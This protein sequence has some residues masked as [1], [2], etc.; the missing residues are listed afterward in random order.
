M[1]GRMMFE[2]RRAVLYQLLVMLGGLG[3]SQAADAAETVRYLL[4]TADRHLAGQQVVERGDDGVVKVRYIFKDNGRGPELVEHIRLSPDGTLA[5]FHVTGTAE[6]GGPIDERFVREG[7]RARWQSAAERGHTDQAEGAFYL[8]RDSSWEVVSASI[9]AAARAGGTLQLLPSGTLTQ[10]KVDEVEVVRAVASAG[11]EATPQRRRVQL[12]VQSGTDFTPA[13]YWATMDAVPHVFAVILPGWQLAIEEGWE[14]HLDALAARQKVASVQWL[15]ALAGRVARPLPGLTVVRN[16]RIF[17]SVAA[18]LRPP[19]DVYLLRGRITAVRP[20][21]S[22]AP[23]AQREIDAAGRVMLPG[24]FDMHGH[25][26]RSGGL[27]HLAAGVTT[28]RDMGSDNTLLQE[29]IDEAQAGDLLWPHIV[30]CGLLEGESP[31][32]SRL[33]TKIKT[34]EEAQAG[35][36]WYAA[37]GYRQVKIYNSFPRHL[38]AQTVAYAKRRGMRVSGHVPAFMRAAEVVEHGFDEIQHINQVVLNFLVT[39]R[40]DTRTLERFVLPA[41]RLAS[42]D[43]DSAPVREF[44]SL[45]KRKRI[46]IDPTLAVFD[47]LKQRDGEKSAPYAAVFDH[48]PPVVQRWM[49][50]GGMKMADDAAAARY[51]ASYAKAVQFVGRL[52]RAGVP[53]VAGTDALPGFTLHSELELYVQAGLTP[54]EALQVATLN[55]ARYS[56]TLASRGSIDIGKIADLVLVDGDPTRHIGDLRRVALVI[57]QGKMVFPSAIYRAMGVAPFVEPMQGFQADEQ[58]T[59]G[60][61]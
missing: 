50:S 51:A 3:L 5:E 59:P 39:P 57:T 42:L 19:A 21:G 46:V 15:K 49:L 26:W 18:R 29:I 33:G 32:S 12:I 53:L 10:L 28:V 24:L 38:L 30:P 60:G 23:G 8:P 20:A 17:D 35:I 7:A 6:M 47:F 36:D 52:H 22:A 58:G 45:L 9:G 41:E 1:P 31:F 48:L 25:A 56:G 34:L 37:R 44:V 13:Y 40:T 14:D 4:F 55:G 11:A 43:L 61:R 16:A 54:A 27:L 2:M